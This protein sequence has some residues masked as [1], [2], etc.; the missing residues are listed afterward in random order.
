M[1]TTLSTLSRVYRCCNTDLVCAGSP[2]AVLTVCSTTH[3][4]QPTEQYAPY[5]RVRNLPNSTQPTEQYAT[6]GSLSVSF[7]TKCKFKSDAGC[8]FFAAAPPHTP[9]TPLPACTTYRPPSLHSSA[10]N[11][12]TLKC[13]VCLWAGHVAHMTAIRIT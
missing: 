11:F 2:T 1:S 10:N 13:W 3:T 7:S 5:R 4:T 12:R 6:C 8:G 9:L